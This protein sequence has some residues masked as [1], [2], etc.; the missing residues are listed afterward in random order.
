MTNTH[1]HETLSSFTHQNFRLVYFVFDLVDADLLAILYG[2]ITRASCDLEQEVTQHLD[3]SLRQVDLGV[4]LCPV[5]L[6]LFVSDAWWGENRCGKALL[7]LIFS[8]FE[9]YRNQKKQ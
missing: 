2:E 8:I 1:N 4:K 5:Q 3:A 9:C 7:T 6:L